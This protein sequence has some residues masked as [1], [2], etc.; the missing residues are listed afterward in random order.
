M[1]RLIIASMLMLSSVSIFAEEAPICNALFI[2]MNNGITNVVAL[3]SISEITFNDDCDRLIVNGVWQSETDSIFELTYGTLPDGIYVNYADNS[4]SV[5]NPYFMQGV[6]VSINNADVVIDN[7]NTSYEIKTTLSGKTSDGQF[8]YNGTYKTTIELDG[9]SLTNTRGAA[10]NIQCGKRI[11]LNLKKGTEST[12]TD[13]K[14]GDQKAALYCKGHLEIDKSGTLNVTGNTAHAISAKEYIKFK[15]S[16][17]II[18]IQ[19]AVK[20]GIHCKQY[21]LA[22]GFKVNISGTVGDG[23]DAEA[24]G[25]EN[26]DGYVD[27]SINI[28]NGDFTITSVADTIKGIKAESVANI[29][30]GTLNITM[31]GK[32]SKGI[33]AG[34]EINIGN[35]DDKT[36]P[37]L[38]VKTSG[39]KYSTSSSSSSNNNNPWGGGRPGGMG[40]QESNGTS[41]KAI[42]GLGVVNIYGG[43]LNISTATDGAEGIESKTQVNIYGGNNYMKCYDDCI[44]SSGPIFF[45]GGTT[46]CWSDGNDAVDSNYG[47]RGAITIAGGNVF[48]YS[49]KGDPEEGLDCDNNSYIVVTGGVAVSAGGSQGGGGGGFPGASSSSSIGSSTQGYFLGSSP[50][51][52]NNTY[53][54]TLCG[55]DGTEICTYKFGKSVSN[56]LS[57]LTAPNLGKGSVTIKYG[58]SQP[59][60]YSENVGD[61]FFISPTVTTSGTTATVTT[62]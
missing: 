59:T 16:D 22:N 61:V 14:N 43:T 55:T 49:T 60:S 8:L 51:S 58:T 45:Y 42:K 30:G 33:K 44:N 35:N 3:D 24:D 9:V 48:A 6:G 57:L 52:Y 32:G 5:I 28:N 34:T 40:P 50:S 12:I 13:G 62:K 41:S 17:G 7:N 53:Y 27:G 54:Y 39:A 36:G 38:S 18:N 20:D 21:F 29:I 15:K 31:S 4:A 1:K 2:T 37:V 23:I 11:A 19:G 10:I 25:E 56:S 46:V 26:E 47:K